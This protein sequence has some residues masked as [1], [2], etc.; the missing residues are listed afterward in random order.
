VVGFPVGKGDLLYATGG[1]QK[2]DSTQAILKFEHLCTDF[3]VY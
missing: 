1:M 2:L 3:I